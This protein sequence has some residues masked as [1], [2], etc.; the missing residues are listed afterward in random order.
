M[1]GSLW[2]LAL[3]VLVFLA[4]HSLT[5]RP[6]LRRRGEAALGRPG[7]L[8][9]YSLLSVAVLAW[10]VAAYAA[11]PVLL[12]WEQQPWMRWAPLLAMLPACLLLFAGMTTPNPFSIGPGGKGY[13][14]GR[15]GILRLTRHPVLWGLALWAGAHLVPNGDVAAWMLFL[16]LLLLALAGPAILDRKRRRSLGEE[17]WRLIAAPTGRCHLAP[18]EIRWWR[19]LGG[20]ALYA[21]LLHAHLPV[22]GASPLP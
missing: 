1:T 20:V 3:A 2:H 12:L 13:D 17:E 22:I 11:A 5:N 14:P 4:S 10:M 15:P 7:F 16:P 21:L 9:A 6:A 18:V 8:L 19:W